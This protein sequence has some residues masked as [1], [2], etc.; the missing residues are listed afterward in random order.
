MIQV[1]FSNVSSESGKALKEL[2][3]AI[4][5]MILPSSPNPHITNMKI[6]SGNLKSF[7]KS[8]FCEDTNLLQIM[9]VAAIASLLIEI[10]ICVENIADAVNELA[11]LAN[12]KGRNSNGGGRNSSKRQCRIFDQ[13][14]EDEIPHVISINEPTLTRSQTI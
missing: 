10:V 2:A 5:T 3:L 9:P 11:S 1:A 7:L 4:K 12:F 13:L 14:P 6:A 8:D